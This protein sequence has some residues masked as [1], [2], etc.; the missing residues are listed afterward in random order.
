MKKVNLV[1]KITHGDFLEV[2]NDIIDGIVD[3]V[4]HDFPY[5]TTQNEWDKKDP[6]F[7][8]ESGWNVIN[9]VT[10]PTAVT[11]AF[12]VQPYTTDL[13]MSNRKNF[14]YDLIWNKV[15]TTSPLNSNR[16][17]LR[18]HEQMN[19]FYRKSP[20]YNVI[21]SKGHK[22]KIVKSRNSK[23]NNNLGEF[24]RIGGYDSTERFPISMFFETKTFVDAVDTEYMVSN[25]GKRTKAIHP[26]EKPLEL[27]IRLLET[28]T[29]PNDLCLDLTSGSGVL[30]EACILTGRRFI[31]IEKDREIV[32][33][34]QYR[35][36]KVLGNVGLF[37]I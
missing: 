16:M 5:G 1:G 23:V 3:F 17:P 32:E 15:L 6:L 33:K 29:K 4:F 37:K 21:K 18:T 2:S 36:D 27:V 35:L 8:I 10:N 14:R 12:S 19:I 11:V 25:G 9:R 28:Y 26:T 31:C 24:N 30:A 20:T 7:L 34:S 13:I 22:R